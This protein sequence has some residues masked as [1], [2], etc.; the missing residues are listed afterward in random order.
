AGLQAVTF[1]PELTRKLTTN[2]T[3]P[4]LATH[5]RDY[6]FIAQ[7]D[8]FYGTLPAK[9]DPVLFTIGK[10]NDVT[11]P[12]PYPAEPMPVRVRL[13]GDGSA[14]ATIKAHAAGG[15]FEGDLEVNQK[16]HTIMLPAVS[17]GDDPDPKATSTV[18]VEATPTEGK[19]QKSSFKVYLGQK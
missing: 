3:N 19:K 8:M 7:R 13:A 10:L 5:T 14:G 11:I 6:S 2:T 9:A 1:N 15:L 17:L 16:D 18:T 12:Y 4:V